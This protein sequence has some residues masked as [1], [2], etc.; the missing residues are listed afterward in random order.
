MEKDEVIVVRFDDDDLLKSAAIAFGSCLLA[1]L[2]ALYI[3][4]HW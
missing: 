2:I 3:S 4:K 1:T